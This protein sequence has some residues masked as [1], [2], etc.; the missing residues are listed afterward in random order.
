MADKSA[1]VDP[2]F[3]SAWVHF[4]EEDSERGAI[5]RPE[6]DKIP[7]SRRPRERIRLWPD[8]SATLQFSGADDRY[9]DQSAQWQKDGDAIVIRANDRQLRLVKQAPARLLVQTQKE[10]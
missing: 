10:G 6:G 3:A 5:Y 9:R 1:K 4:F 2:L 8:G 7:L